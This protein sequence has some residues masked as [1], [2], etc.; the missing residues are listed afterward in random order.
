LGIEEKLFAG[1]L[2]FFGVGGKR[3]GDEFDLAVEIGGHA[4][5][6]A[7]EGVLAAADHSVANC[8]AGGC[9][10]WRTGR[11]R[12][13]KNGFVLARPFCHERERRCATLL[14]VAAE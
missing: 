7:D 8:A 2:E 9:S 10:A 5:D 14:H 4:V 11:G 3:A 6:R 13:R 1:R 12:F